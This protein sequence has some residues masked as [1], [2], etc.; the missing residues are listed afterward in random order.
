MQINSRVFG[1]IEIDEARVVN[2]TEP[3]PGFASLK[4]FAILD[5]DPESPF[6]WF[7]SVERSD[8]C[9]LIADPRE[10]FPDYRVEVS[11]TRLGAL[12]LKRVEDAAVA[13]VLT[14]GEDLTKTTANLLAPLIFN[15]TRNLARQIILE[16]SDYPVR[17][18]V[19]EEQRLAAEAG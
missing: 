1:S 13:V 18:R 14:A 4:C 7:Q 12:D 3:M 9:F 15:T 19:F 8:V 11:E 16:G 6:K 2:L 17:A 10:F 5:P